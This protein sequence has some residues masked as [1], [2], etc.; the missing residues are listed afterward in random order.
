MLK[1]LNIGIGYYIIESNGAKDSSYLS[2][3]YSDM[4]VYEKLNR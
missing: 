2:Y 4:F 3:Y 1:V